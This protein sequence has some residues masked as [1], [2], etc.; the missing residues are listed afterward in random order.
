MKILESFIYSRPATANYEQF[1]IF[2]C[3]LETS[4]EKLIHNDINTTRFLTLCFC[5]TEIMVLLDLFKKQ[6]V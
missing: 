6:K 4:G 2:K 1:K 5:L 3:D